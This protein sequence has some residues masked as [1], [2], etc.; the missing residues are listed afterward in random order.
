MSE[1]PKKSNRRRRRPRR[2]SRSKNTPSHTAEHP[3]TNAP[4]Q[5]AQSSANRS[6]RRSGRRRRPQRD[7]PRISRG[8]GDLVLQQH[9]AADLNVSP[10]NKDIFIY[11]YTLRPQSLLDN[12][13]TGPSVVENM[14]YEDVRSDLNLSR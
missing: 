6:N 5:A 2:Q 7:E 10:I 11:T 1:T 3:D 8:S 12:Y 9:N 13:Q 4:E 14:E